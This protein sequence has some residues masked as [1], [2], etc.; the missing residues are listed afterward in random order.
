MKNSVNI[1]GNLGADP[2]VRYTQSGTA[3]CNM[4]IATNE[5][6]TDKEGQKQERTEWHRV[7]VWGKSAENCGKYLAK[8]RLV[9]ITGKLQT[10]QW[11][12]RDGNKRYTTEI[13]ANNVT[14]L[15]T[16]KQQ[17]QNRETEAQLP[18]EGVDPSVSAEAEQVFNN[19]E[20]VA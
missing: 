15:G 9:D 2:E 16:G 17:S 13:V 14:F 5:R 11:D 10:R 18:L 1:M 7:V 6:W 12:D 20:V 3:V 19:Q 4:R 8:G